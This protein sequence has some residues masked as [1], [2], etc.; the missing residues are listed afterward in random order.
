MVQRVMSQE[1]SATTLNLC[2]RRTDNSSHILQA[3]DD[4]DPG[5]DERPGR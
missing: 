1:R 5:N 4:E 3:V 2:T